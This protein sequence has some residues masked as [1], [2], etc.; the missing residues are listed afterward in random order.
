MPSRTL[1]GWSPRL[2]TRST[3]QVFF[4]HELEMRVSGIRDTGTDLVANSFW[5]SALVPG[6]RP[7]T[8]TVTVMVTDNLLSV[9]VT[10]HVSV[11]RATDA[12]HYACQAESQI[13]LRNLANGHVVLPAPVTVA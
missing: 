2:G 9:T 3:R 12:P 10:V 7:S 4:K 11:L 8:G 1:E 6:H 13:W 5:D